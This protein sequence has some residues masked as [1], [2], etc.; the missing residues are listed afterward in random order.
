MNV[1]ALFFL[2][3]IVFLGNLLPTLP[4]IIYHS[5]TSRYN[6]WTIPNNTT[7]PYGYH[8]VIVFVHGVDGCSAEF[9]HMRSDFLR[10]NTTFKMIAIDFG[11][12]AVI[13]VHEEV[14]IMHRI[15]VNQWSQIKSL[16]FVGHSKGGV[17]AILYTKKYPQKIV[18]IVTISSPIKGSLIVSYN[19]IYPV[20]R[21]ELGYKSQTFHNLILSKLAYKLLHIVPFFD[22]LIQPVSVAKSLLM[23]RFTIIM[24][25]TVTMESCTIKRS[26]MMFISSFCNLS[27]LFIKN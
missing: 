24:V 25:F 6:N 2:L 14:E 7:L 26:L 4:S 15:L 13:S 8:D 5:I 19:P 23:G 20:A 12:N 18:S 21:K 27:H 22:H 3:P 17:T 16:H 9:L 11:S 1:L 10:R